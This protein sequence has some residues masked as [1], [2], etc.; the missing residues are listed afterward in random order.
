MKRLIFLF[1]LCFVTLMS[2]SQTYKL[3]RT[4]NYHNQLKLNTATGKVE[5]VQDD[6]Q[7]WII[8]TDILPSGDIPG[9]FVLYETENIWTFILLDSFNGRLWQCQ[10]SVNGT[11]YTMTVPINLFPLTSTL[12]HKSVF[13]IQPMVS[14][15]QFYLIND[16]TGDMWQF[17]WSTQ[18]DDYRWIKKI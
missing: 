5:Q 4:Q 12:N 10:F 9:R 2:F 15:F 7:S 17:Q 13:T 18:G 3:Y 6:G 8:N 14:M 16:D 1:V 11:E